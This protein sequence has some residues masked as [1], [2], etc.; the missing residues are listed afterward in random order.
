MARANTTNT[1]AT[2]SF[3]TQRTRARVLRRSRTRIRVV[4]P[5]ARAGDVIARRSMRL[6]PRRFR[7]RQRR[8]TPPPT[9]TPPTMTNARSSFTRFREDHG[10]NRARAPLAPASFTHQSNRSSSSPPRAP[11]S[12]P[13]V[14]SMSTDR[15]L[16]STRLR[17]DS[18]RAPPARVRAVSRVWSSGPSRSP[19]CDRS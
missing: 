19:S 1:N 11:S 17:L 18:T 12:I 16:D 5:F 15:P 8:T 10:P 13:L 7:A 9:T 6:Y 4:D 3:I 2:N 14:D